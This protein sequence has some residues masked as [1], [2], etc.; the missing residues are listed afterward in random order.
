MQRQS[1]IHGICLRKLSTDKS[2][3]IILPPEMSSGLKTQDWSLWHGMSMLPSSSLEARISAFISHI[4][5]FQQATVRQGSSLM[6]LNKS[7]NKD[8]P[9]GTVTPRRD[10]VM[11]W[12]GGSLQQGDGR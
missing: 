12:Y 2:L 9:V 8:Q 4:Q 11:H 10:A 5:R 1:F 7:N 3:L 6:D